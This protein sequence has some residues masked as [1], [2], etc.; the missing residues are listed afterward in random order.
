MNWYDVTVGA[1]AGL[2]LQS[3]AYPSAQSRYRR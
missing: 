3:V 2:L 1:V